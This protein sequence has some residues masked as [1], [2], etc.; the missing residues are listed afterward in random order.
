MGNSIV[1]V[2]GHNLYHGLRSR[3]GHVY[4]WLGPTRAR[5]AHAGR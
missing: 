2:D 5:T 4:L 3:Y 1:Y